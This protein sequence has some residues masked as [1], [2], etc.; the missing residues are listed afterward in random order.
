MGVLNSNFEDW[1]RANPDLPASDFQFSYKKLNPAGS[2]FDYAKLCDVSKNVISKMSAE[3]VC[4]DYESWARE[5]D[6]EFADVIFSDRN[7]LVEIFSIGRGGK[8]PR[9][10]FAAWKDVKDFIGFFY[11]DY[12][13]IT[14]KYPDNFITDDI[15]KVLEDFAERVHDEID[16]EGVSFQR[17]QMNALERII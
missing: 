15:K 1:R 2:L 7:K 4:D 5:F 9:K 16:F 3:K 10:D 13:K 11:D 12:F 8:K 17:H 14:D 6:K